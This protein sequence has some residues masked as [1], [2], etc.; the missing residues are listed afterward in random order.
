MSNVKDDLSN[1]CIVLLFNFFYS[2]LYEVHQIRSYLF[3][4]EYAD[5][6]TLNDYLSKY[7]DKLDWGDKY[8]LTLQL[9]SAV[10]FI[11]G[12]NIIHR[13]LVMCNFIIRFHILQ[14]N[15]KY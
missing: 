10:A 5:N 4:L 7:F 9:S 1:N 14:Y 8:R 15:L 13:D 3:V 6:G 11:H 2:I 12:H